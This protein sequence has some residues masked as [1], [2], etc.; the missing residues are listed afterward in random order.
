MTARATEARARLRAL[1]NDEGDAAWSDADIIR[2]DALTRLGRPA[3]VVSGAPAEIETDHS[4]RK[5]GTVGTRQVSTLESTTRAD[6]LQAWRG[7]G[8]LCGFPLPAPHDFG[9]GGER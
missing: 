8:A 2:L 4:E 6:V 5:W 1:V 9:K 7:V 3:E